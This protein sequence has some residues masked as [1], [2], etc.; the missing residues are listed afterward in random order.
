[1]RTAI[2]GLV[3]GFT[4]V[5]LLLMLGG[6]LSSL[7]ML[8]AETRRFLGFGLLT[9][10]SLLVGLVVA[11]WQAPHGLAP[12]A[13]AGLVGA[14]FVWLVRVVLLADGA[15]NP[16]V[17]GPIGLVS[18]A[19]SATVGGLLA[20]LIEGGGGQTALGFPPVARVGI[21]AAC[22]WL[23]FELAARLIGG[24]GI[25]PAIGNV[26]AGDMAGVAL[27]MGIAAWVIVRYGFAHGIPADD[28]AYRWTPT[29]IGFGVLGAVVT[30][31]L[32]WV[33]A[34]IDLVLWALPENALAGF[35]EGLQAGTWVVVLL[36]VVNGIV[37]PVCEEIAWRGVVQTALVRA[38]GPVVGVGATLVL[39]AFKHV[40]IDAS[41][42]R[43]TTLLMLGLAFGVVRHCWGTGSSTVAHVLVN[44]YSTS[45]L[46]ASV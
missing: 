28:W 2:A 31:A 36:L 39:F 44:L 3:G 16:L 22:L 32:M 30:V 18:V 13:I 5:V 45:V 17:F 6:P 11:L 40:A 14:C 43:L 4:I 25:G 19:L 9:I 42:G 8:S 37:A 33:T 29:T 46:I 1:M 26:L 12:A 21:W 35:A 27:G 24:L 38:W 34:Q 7:D 15:Y 41:F 20:H 23:G 10:V